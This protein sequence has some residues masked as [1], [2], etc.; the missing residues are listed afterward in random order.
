MNFQFVIDKTIISIFFIFLLCGCS[1]VHLDL[2]EADPP[3]CLNDPAPVRL[4][5]V[6]HF[7]DNIKA[8]FGLFGFVTW[9]QPPMQRV[10]EE[11][12][13]EYEGNGIININIKSKFGF[14]DMLLGLPLS[15]LWFT[16]T[17]IIEGD[18]VIIQSSR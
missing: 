14:V 16:R 17:Y 4:L 12:L 9:K 7:K 3:L 13:D 1:T 6:K 15:P 11:K 5:V 2:L 8:H 10:F 18:V